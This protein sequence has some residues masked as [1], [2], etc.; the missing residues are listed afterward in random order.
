M[1][2]LRGLIEERPKTDGHGRRYRPL[3][4]NNLVDST[5]RYTQGFG[6]VLLRDA[7]GNQVFLA[8]NLTGDDGRLHDWAGAHGVWA[9]GGS[10]G[11]MLVIRRFTMGHGSP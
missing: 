2:E 11:D 9:S 4:E 5:Q 6:H 8:K 3:P 7:Q 10:H 1:P